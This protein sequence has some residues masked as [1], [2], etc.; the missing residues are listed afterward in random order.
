MNKKFITKII[1]AKKLELEAFQ[2][3]LPD[4]LNDRMKN[5][6]TGAGDWLKECAVE[7]YLAGKKETKSC[8]DERDG[9]RE[10]ESEKA[11]RYTGDN[12]TK[13]SEKTKRT[14]KV[15]IE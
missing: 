9:S 2:E 12:F 7:I 14:K 8:K 3:L 11:D 15:I 1:Q 13:K 10:N 5:W 4:E 6:R